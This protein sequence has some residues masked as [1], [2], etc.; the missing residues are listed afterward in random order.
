MGLFDGLAATAFRRDEGGRVYFAPLGSRGRSFLVSPEREAHL[1]RFLRVY[2]AAAIVI[3]VVGVQLFRWQALWFLIPALAGLYGKFWH[4]ARTLP[5]SPTPAPPVSRSAA[6]AAYSR[7][8]GRPMLGAMFVASLL[9]AA[10]G[11]WMI[12][13]GSGRDGYF[14]AGFFALCA[15]SA[16]IQ[17]TRAAR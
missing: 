10:I 8:I 15:V 4:F 2:Y 17:F 6:F 11:M 13:E 14:V 3:T 5:V 16:V 12:F 7:A 9:F 1:S